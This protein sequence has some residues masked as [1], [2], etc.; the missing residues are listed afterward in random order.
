M[1]LHQECNTVA[2][3]TKTLINQDRDTLLRHLGRFQ[4][5]KGQS[6]LGFGHIQRQTLQSQDRGGQISLLR[7]IVR[8]GVPPVG[9]RGRTPIVQTPLSWQRP[10]TQIPS[11]L[12]GTYP[13]RALGNQPFP[14]HRQGVSLYMSA[15]CCARSSNGPPRGAPDARTWVTPCPASHEVHGAPPGFGRR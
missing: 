11:R 1:P 15:P 2:I 9:L 12:E 4:P 7:A 8:S 6:E 14:A 13:Q 10:C 3:Y 5:K